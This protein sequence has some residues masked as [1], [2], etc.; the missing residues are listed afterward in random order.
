MDTNWGKILLF[1]LLFGAVGFL[2]GRTT[3]GGC[4]RGGG[5][6]KGAC[7]ASACCENGM[8]G[9]RHHGKR[10]EGVHAIVK[11]LEASGFEGDTV[12]TADGATIKVS[13]GGGR[14]EVR[15]ERVKEGSREIQLE[16]EDKD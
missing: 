14:T 16:I 12:I 7:V 4:H 13:R 2:I 10:G 11:G 9:E 15:V 5:C 1:S 3:G 6:G 8:R